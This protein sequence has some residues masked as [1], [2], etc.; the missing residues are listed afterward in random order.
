MAKI[1]IDAGHGGSGAN[2]DPGAV[3]NGRKESDDVLKLAKAVEK[4]L[5]NQGQTV[6]MTRTTDELVTLANR[7]KIGNNSNAD[8]FV[9]LHRNSFTNSTANGLEIWIQAGRSISTTE[10][11]TSVYNALVSVG[12][13][14]KRGVKKGDY[15][16][17]RESKMP[18]MLVE[19]GFI[20]NVED[21]RLFD[22]NFDKYA[23]AIAKGIMYALGLTYKEITPIVKKTLYRVQVGAFLSKANAEKYL[24][25]VQADGYKDSFIVEPINDIMYRVQVGSF[26]VK[27][28]A[29][30][31]AKEIQKTGRSTIIKEYL[32]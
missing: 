13:Q 31:Y 16:V 3:F 12:V 21:N 29:E 28:N 25:S 6:I 2:G 19:L 22:V 26:S 32:G 24:K 20:S 30:A 7:T 18:A 15:H 17:C 14:T 11:A 8:I 27:A 10:A 23:L 4:I 1:C 9:S 5:I